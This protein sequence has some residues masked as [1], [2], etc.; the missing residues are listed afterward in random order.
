MNLGKTLALASV[1]A[2]SACPSNNVTPPNSDAGTCDPSDPACSAACQTDMD[3]GDIQ[4]FACINYACTPVC[5]TK[6]NC[7]AHPA[8]DNG[9]WPGCETGSCICDARKCVGSFCAGDSECGTNQAC[10]NGACVAAEID[11]DSC[12][13]TPSVVVLRKDQ[14]VTF[15][16]TAYK[17][18]TV[19]LVGANPFV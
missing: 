17:G 8:Y 3:C 9:A 1:L 19:S 2:L 10:K 4:T 5:T 18:T 12:E 6:A 16:A 15:T 11:P 13:I 7:M 14:Q